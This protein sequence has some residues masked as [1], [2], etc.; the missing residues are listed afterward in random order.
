MAAPFSFEEAQ[1]Q[2]QADAPQPGLAAWLAEHPGATPAQMPKAAQAA[3]PATFSFD[4]AKQPPAIKDTRTT[5]LIANVGAGTS[6]TTAGLLGLPVDIVTGALNLGTGALRAIGVKAPPPIQNP[7]GGSDTFKSLFGFAGADPRT[8]A[9][10]DTT[11]QV[12]RATGAGAASMLLPWSLARG[13]A[14][15]A[16]IPGAVQRGIGAGGAPTQ[17]AAG[18]GA[19]AGGQI[20]E[21]LVPEP[22][23]PLASFGGQM[24]GGGAVLAPL[25]G[26]RAVVDAGANRV[27]GFVQWG[28]KFGERSL[29]S[30]LHTSVMGASVP[31]TRS[32]LRH[33]N[34]AAGH[35]FSSVISNRKGLG[36]IIPLQFAE[37]P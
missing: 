11:E 9:P 17:I 29:I 5:G 28:R 14:P 26:A 35:I 4:E 32:S 34:Q 1:P 20:A 27:R 22:Y 24:L 30:G 12:A 2:A 31:T 3:A 18:A 23:K 36:Q 19:G 33:Q 13:I 25:A 8:I 7:F 21:N 6:E 15:M 16:G 37:W 10:A